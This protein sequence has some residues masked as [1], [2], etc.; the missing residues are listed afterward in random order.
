MTLTMTPSTYSAVFHAT[1][2]GKRR[3]KQMKIGCLIFSTII[4]MTP[5][6]DIL[7][8]WLPKA[9]P[10]PP[11]TSKVISVSNVDQFFEAV[12][13]VQPGETISLKDGTY[14][15]PRYI[16]IRTDNVTLR[17]AS[18]NRDA[19]IIDGS[20]SRHGELVGF[21]SCSGV[22]VA[23]LT[24]QNIKWNGFKINSDHNVQN[25][26]NYNCVIHNIWQRGV[27]S[28]R[29]PEKNRE[30]TRPK[31]MRIRYCLFYNDHPKRYSDDLKDTPDTFQGNYIGGIDTMYA[32]GW[33]ISDAADNEPPSEPPPLTG[34]EI[35]S[36]DP[37]AADT[38]T[39]RDGE[40]KLLFENVTAETVA[41]G[42]AAA[43]DEG[44]SGADSAA[45]KIRWSDRMLT[46]SPS[47]IAPMEIEIWY[48]EAYVTSGSTNQA[49]D[50]ST[51]PQEMRLL[52]SA[53]DGQHLLIEG[54]IAETV[55]SLHEIDVDGDAVRFTVTFENRG[56]E[57]VDLQWMQPCLRVGEFTGLPQE[58]YYKKC[59]I[60]TDQGIQYLD[61][62]PRTL[63]ALYRGGQIY[64]PEGIP[65]EDVNP[66]P[67][68]TIK[69]VNSLIGAVSADGGSLVAIAFE[70]L[71]ELFQGVIRC[72]HSDPRIG[73]LDPG[74]RKTIHGCFY[75]MENDTEELLK[76]YRRDFV[77]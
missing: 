25:L 1:F 68:S 35:T 6:H 27:K 24:I 5:A 47:R 13:K 46:V 36:L 56:P 38:V 55:Y 39:P 31:G 65:L 48:I 15:M 28:V 20:K 21:R 17:S 67:L 57:Y 77:D 16:E 22:T 53:P 42:T 40:G 74:E 7:P 62:L 73:G 49:W 4:A 54:T 14:F 30:Q 37:V 3:D 69:P 63:E 19:V 41:V 72:I 58:E 61:E 32:K 12:D 51:L 44:D 10:L 66:R 50:K 75:C 2:S 59:F 71:Q 43:D 26:T 8:S 45:V 23:D 34:E 70:P 29:V 11:P 9:P 18:G 64:V 52:N 76:R 33:I 60:Y